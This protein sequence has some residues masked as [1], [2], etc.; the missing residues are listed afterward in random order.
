MEEIQRKGAQQDTIFALGDTV[1]TINPPSEA[2]TAL[3]IRRSPAARYTFGLVLLA[4]VAGLMT[5]VVQ[6]PNFPTSPQ[7]VV[8]QSSEAGTARPG[9]FPMPNMAPDSEAASAPRLAQP[10]LRVDSQLML[11]SPLAGLLQSVPSPDLDRAIDGMW[12][13]EA[14]KV[15]LRKQV[16][17][18]N[19]RVAL[20]VLSDWDAEDGDSVTVSAAGYSQFVRLSHRPT[21]IAVPYTVGEPLTVMGAFD[22]DNRGITV[23][24]H[25][26]DTRVPLSM[27]LGSTVLVPTP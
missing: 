18:G 26:G 3:P 14:E 24:V 22:G 12:F 2:E 1:P 11:Q 27:R 4:L 17:A 23:A 13:S 16:A 7:A 5:G 10:A 19:V 25:L 15:R 20:I 6:L 9:K 8:P 21:T